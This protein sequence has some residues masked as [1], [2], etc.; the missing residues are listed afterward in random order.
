MNETVLSDAHRDLGAKMVPFGGWNMP[1]SYTDIRS[2]HLCVRERVGVFDLCHMGRV[3]LRGPDAIAFADAL[4]TNGIAKARA[5]RIRY[6]LVTRENG[7]IID[8]IL[9]YRD[10]DEV[11]MVVNASNREKDLEWMRSKIAD[12]K[13]SIDDETEELGMIAVQGPKAALVL[14]DLGLGEAG[15]LKYYSF[16]RIT[17][18]EGSVHVSRTGYTGEDGF[19]LIVPR[20][21]TEALFRRALE[22]GAAHGVQPC[23]LGARDSLRL[24]AGMP[25]YG[26]EIDDET[27]PWEAGLDFAVRLKREFIGAEALRKIKA[28]GPARRLIGLEV[29]GPRIPRQGYPVLAG[30]EIVGAIASGTR[31]PTLDKNIATAM[32][33]ADAA[34]EG[35]SLRVDERGKKVTAV[36][37]D[38][39]FYS[40]KK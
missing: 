3:F 38:M 40:R 34:A 17:G 39:P 2:E 5:G 28:E 30:E 12:R 24:E 31:S 4:Q 36:R 11:M 6:G 15:D 19:E 37:V 25:L 20:A 7:T 8:D 29:E 14:N 27:N 18:A 16:T 10:E 26:H 23:G 9:S 13:L 33:A 1:V 21:E 35:V 22:V 32:V